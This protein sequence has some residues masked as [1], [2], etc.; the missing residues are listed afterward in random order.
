MLAASL[1]D[2]GKHADAVVILHEVFVS[3]TRLLGTEHESTLTTA[4]NLAHSLAEIG[5]KAEAG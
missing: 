1:S 2:Q 3:M 5:Y 4:N